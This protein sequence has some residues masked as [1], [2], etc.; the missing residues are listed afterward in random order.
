LR[1]LKDNYRELEAFDYY[2]EAF[3]KITRLFDELFREI[4]ASKGNLRLNR[5]FQ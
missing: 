5:H 1:L 3:I 4:E 2:C